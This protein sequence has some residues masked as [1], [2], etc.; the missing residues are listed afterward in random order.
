M[1]R[2]WFV[3]AAA[4]AAAPLLGLAGCGR[5]VNVVQA[6]P[7]SDVGRIFGSNLN[8][9]TNYPDATVFNLLKATAAL[10][11]ASAQQI[12]VAWQLL[13]TYAAMPTVA[14]PIPP[15]AALSFP[16]D[17]G[18][19][20]DTTIEW[21]YFTLSLPLANG[22]LV[23]VIA[24]FFRKALVSSATLPSVPALSRQLYS[25]SIGVTIEMPGQQ[26]VHY[27][28]PTTSFAG[29][30]GTVTVGNAPFRMVLGKNAIVGG[31]DVFPVHV[32]V[33]DAGDASVGRPPV[34]VDVDCAATNPFFY[35]GTNGYV[36]DPVKPGEIPGVGWYYYSWPQQATTGTVTIAGTQYAV[37]NGLCWMDHQWGGNAPPTSGP[38][39]S[40]SGWCW[41]EFQFTGN[42]S[43]TLANP[44][45]PIVGGVLPANNPG[46]GTYVENGSSTQIGALLQVGAYVQ[47]PNTT[48]RYPSDWTLEISGTGVALLVKPVVKVEPQTLWMGT[49]AEYSEANASVTATG[50]INGQAV[51]LSGVGYCEGVGFED[52]ANR[53][54]RDVA[55]LQTRLASMQRAK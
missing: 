39:Y 42:R 18:E 12:E 38:A 14:T 45:G 51:N 13:G 24:N 1:H 9:I 2:R 17:H 49:L 19:H 29:V 32:H 28:W 30:D 7:N 34:T 31:A 46:F 10:P 47:S 6:R 5:G 25:T 53:V 48:G 23:S 44:H 54:A 20:S 33:E 16:A 8:A 27:A 50:I 21:R 11:N 36:G 26:G 52:P 43:L 15:A 3:V 40:W 4:S 37:N 41:F 55:F 35:Q 22:G